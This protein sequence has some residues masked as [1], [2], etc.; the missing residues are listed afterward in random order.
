MSNYNVWE[1]RYSLWIFLWLVEK[2]KYWNCYSRLHHTL[3][4]KP[5][6][7]K[8]NC[9]IRHIYIHKFSKEQLC[10]NSPSACKAL[11]NPCSRTLVWLLHSSWLYLAVP[12]EREKKKKV[13][14]RV[15]T[16]ASCSGCE[17]RTGKTPGDCI[18]FPGEV[19]NLTHHL[20]AHFQ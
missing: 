2:K 10:N 18:A 20:R 11:D 7:N 5:G 16:P 6:K 14:V 3:I 8:W 1:K 19:H 17:L 4:S 12:D 9:Y 13:D 15:C